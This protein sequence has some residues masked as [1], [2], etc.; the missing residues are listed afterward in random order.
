MRFNEAAALLPREG[1]LGTRNYATLPR[2]SMRP[3]HYC[4][5]RGTSPAGPYTAHPRFNEA[6]ALLPREGRPARIVNC[7]IPKRFNEAAALLPREGARVDSET[8]HSTSGFNEAAALLPREGQRA[9]LVVRQ[10]DRLQ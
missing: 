10:T 4:R 2:A 9:K 8:S 3:R 1:A 5:G 7:G 6:A